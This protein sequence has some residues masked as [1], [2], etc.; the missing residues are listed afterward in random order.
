MSTNFP[1]IKARTRMLIESM[2]RADRRYKELEEI[3]RIPAATWRGFWNRETYPSGPMIEAL[4]RQWPTYA[5]WLST[6]I[7]DVD[8][9]HTAP[10]SAEEFV[11]ETLADVNSNANDYFR[12]QLDQIPRR[13]KTTRLALTG[14]DEAMLREEAE[15]FVGGIPNPQ[16]KE[17][18]STTAPIDLSVLDGPEDPEYTEKLVSAKALLNEHKERLYR[19]QM[20][21]LREKKLKHTQSKP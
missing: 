5:F 14:L 18:G 20:A 3:T 1:D 15:E 16:T 9:G 19:E 7:T 11:Q 21:D 10:R 8:A 13:Y 6:G 12:F 17:R 4:S 2:V